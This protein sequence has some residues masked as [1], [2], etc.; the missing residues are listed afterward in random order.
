M[1][2]ILLLT[3]ISLCLGAGLARVFA[4]DTKYLA[5]YP[6][7]QSQIDTMYQGVDQSKLP[8]KILLV[9]HHLLAP[10]LIARALA[11][12][13]TTKKQTVV[14]IS[15][16][17]FSAGEGFAISTSDSWQTPYGILKPDKGLITHLV[18]AGATLNSVPFENE[19][20]IYNIIPF[21]RRSLPN[22]RIVP[23]MIRD[24]T[25]SSDLETLVQALPADA[26]IIGSFDFS[27]E[28]T[29]EVA[30]AQDKMSLQV[31]ESLDI[32][33]IAQ[34]HIDSRPGLA[35]LMRYAQVH[36]K[37]Q[38]VLLG[39]TNSAK[40]LKQPTQPDVTSYITGY[41]TD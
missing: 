34:V 16:N 13:A 39:A 5:A 21:I 28:V 22:A 26:L 30:D 24:T 6:M 31:L 37:R 1:K 18:L 23:L 40:V 27:H 25:S 35:M 14:L 15:P 32:P 11:G 2:K 8:T 9:N 7:L 10:D 4:P 3:L 41:F 20:G 38:F 33:A 12:V 17:H 29:S 36:G 19:H